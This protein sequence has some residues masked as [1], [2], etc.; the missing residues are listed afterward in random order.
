MLLTCKIAIKKDVLRLQ[1]EGELDQS[2]VK[3]LKER[4]CE[5]IDRYKINY[6]ILNMEKLMFMDSSGI[7]FLIGRYNSL[8]LRNGQIILC[9]LNEQIK[10]IVVLSG[11]GRIC[12]IFK[13]ETE[14]F[15]YVEGC[16][17]GN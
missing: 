3:D 10:R 5:L 13:D 8:K 1:L 2:S 12:K 6:L 15:S 9:C 16:K 17:S 14:C 11:I 4:V 7:G